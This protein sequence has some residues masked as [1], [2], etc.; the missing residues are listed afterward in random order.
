MKL[1]MNLSTL[2]HVDLETQLRICAD[3]GFGAVGLRVN[4]LEEYFAL[5][6]SAE[7][8]KRRCESLDLLPL[9]LN[10]FPNWIYVRG[11]EQ[12]AT[13]D[14]FVQFSHLASVLGCPILILPTQCDGQ[15]D[16]ALARENF[17]ELCRLAS[18]VDV[19][20]ALEFVPWSPIDTAKKA[21]G[22]VRS[23]NHPCGGLVLD[24]FH[25]V[26]GGSRP[27]D[28]QEIPIEKVFLVHL[29]DALDVDT[30]V[31]T[32]CRNYRVPPGDGVLVLDDFLEYLRAAK[33]DGYY[34]LEV[35]NKDY[36]QMNA[37]QIARHGKESVERILTS[38]RDRGS[39]ERSASVDEA[40][41][42]RMV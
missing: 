30:D 38:A 11:A 32:L 19:R 22:V 1:C 5:G 20:V 3:V 12:Q 13:M 4:K 28:L 34:S 16:E 35:L 36:F 17:A 18:R 14:R 10:Y 42:T 31:A 37:L 33:Y 41:R 39:D 2:A 40:V 8:V 25:Y 24:S 26:K 21:W 6:K 9:E 29:A 7:D 23:V 27:A 15:H